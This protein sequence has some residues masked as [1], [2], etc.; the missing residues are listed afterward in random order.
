MHWRPAQNFLFTSDQGC[1]MVYF[2]TKNPYL[3]KFLRALDCKMLISFMDI[4]YILRTLGIS[5][6]NLVN[7]L[8]IF[9]VFG[10]MHQEK[11]GNPASNEC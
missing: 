9:Y 10:I 2:Q 4:W 8:Y 5:Y 1:Q 3:G 6:A 11:S 7:F